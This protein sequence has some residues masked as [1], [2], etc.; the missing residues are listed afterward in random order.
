MGGEDAESSPPIR[1]IA[2][3]L[4]VIVASALIG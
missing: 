4:S 2:F 1:I 3:L